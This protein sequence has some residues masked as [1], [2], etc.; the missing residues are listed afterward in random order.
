VPEG[1][2][3][4]VPKGTTLESLQFISDDVLEYSAINEDLGLVGNSN[5]LE[6]WLLEVGL[7]SPACCAA[8]GRKVYDARLRRC[9][10]EDV[11]QPVPLC[12]ADCAANAAIQTSSAN[13]GEIVSDPSL[14]AHRR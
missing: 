6:V 11:P 3:L 7:A 10:A 12:R 4:F 9:A 1:V 2:N 8:H 14:K 13:C 5:W